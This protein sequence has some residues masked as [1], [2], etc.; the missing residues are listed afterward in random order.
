MSY[1]RRK[2]AAA[3]YFRWMQKE[4]ALGIAVTEWWFWAEWH[5]R[6]CSV[7]REAVP[8]V[9]L[10]EAAELCMG[11]WSHQYLLVLEAVRSGRKK[12]IKPKSCGGSWLCFAAW[13]YLRVAALQLYP[14][15]TCAEE[16]WASR[17]MCCS[18]QVCDQKSEDFFLLKIAIVQSLASKERKAFQSLYL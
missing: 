8:S 17:E 9:T 6:W 5:W 10:R 11:L 16:H 14:R 3:C 2:V 13:K 4:S 12:R 1:L 7:L 18:L 15:L